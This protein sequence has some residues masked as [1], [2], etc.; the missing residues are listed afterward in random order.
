MNL[1]EFQE[2]FKK[3]IASDNTITF[4]F[5]MI[6][7]L[8]RKYFEIYD[9]IIF[10]VLK[11]R[12]KPTEGYIIKDVHGSKMYLNIGDSGISRD[13]I[14]A[15][16]REPTHTKLMQDVLKKGYVVMDIGAN[17]GYYA[18]MEAKAVGKTGIVYAI[19]PVPANMSL[20]KRNI[21]LN[22]YKNIETFETAIGGE[23]KKDYICIT[24][25]S[26]W[27]AMADNKNKEKNMKFK[28][29]IPV[30]V[31]KLDTFIKDK[32]FPD[33]IR[34][35]V[36][37]YETEIIKGMEGILQCRK[38]LK[39]FI[40]LHSFMIKDKGIGI[41]KKLEES[42]FKIKY[43]FRD[44]CPLMLNKSKFIRKSYYYLGRKINGVYEF[45]YKDINYKDLLY[46]DLIIKEEAFHVYFERK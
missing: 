26:N 39:I 14:L 45:N 38:P 46:P 9:N 15:G 28:Y 12:C 41:L 2:K 25:K 32:R 31:L 17:I 21:S 20:L 43:F 36:E 1:K 8:F 29:R 22:N 16:T 11:F 42:G 23:N 33:I 30:K 3:R 10:R 4:C 13:L 27:C 19:E 5:R 7:F 34:M 18:L 24:T 6:F 44:R 40:E 37:G 35:D